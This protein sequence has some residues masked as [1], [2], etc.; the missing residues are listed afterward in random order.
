M[1]RRFVWEKVA[2]WQDVTRSCK[3]P[4]SVQ[5]VCEYTCFRF[6]HFVL[7]RII[8]LHFSLVR[9]TPFNSGFDTRPPTW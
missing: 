6:A 8:R 1:V 2:G 7:A 4:I 5:L 9:F 3:G